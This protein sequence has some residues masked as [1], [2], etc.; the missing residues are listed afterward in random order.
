[1][2]SHRTVSPWSRYRYRY[3]NRQ[4]VAYDSSGDGNDAAHHKPHTRKGPGVVRDQGQ[5][6]VPAHRAA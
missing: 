5:R 2:N 6:T 3:R 4:R 1:M